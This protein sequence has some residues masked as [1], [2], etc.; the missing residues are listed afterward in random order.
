MTRFPPNVEQIAVEPEG[1]RAWL[2][3]RRNDTTIRL[4]LAPEDI[5]HLTGLLAKAREVIAAPQC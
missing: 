4:P 5:D 1:G 3:V 2:K